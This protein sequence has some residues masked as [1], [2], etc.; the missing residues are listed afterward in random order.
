MILP[1]ARRCPARW[2]RICPACSEFAYF[3]A[4]FAQTRRAIYPRR[5]E[6]YLERKFGEAYRRYKERVPRYLLD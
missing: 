5:E 2:Q 6:S 1:M 4:D 3:C